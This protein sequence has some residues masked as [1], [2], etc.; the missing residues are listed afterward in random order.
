[1]KR[2]QWLLAPLALC[3]FAAQAAEVDIDL[4]VGLSEERQDATN[5]WS[6]GALV[7]FGESSWW[8]K[9]E[10]AIQ[11]KTYPL[12]GGLDRETTVG[13]LKTWKFERSRLFL[14]GGY[15]HANYQQGANEGTSTGP[16]ARVGV[17][18]PIAS[19]RF[20]MGVDFKKAWLRPWTSFGTSFDPEY[21]Q[22]TMRLGWRL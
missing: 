4:S 1:M 12:Y 20:S 5:Q 11:R 18:W 6:F 10:I 13:A 17:M 8:L 16:F 9:P 21:S 14:G 15:A 7:T 2:I 3:G 19:G 22:I